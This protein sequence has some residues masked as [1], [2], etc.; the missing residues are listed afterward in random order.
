VVGALAVACLSLGVHPAQ[1]A[2]GEHHI[3]GSVFAAG[4]GGL[5]EVYVNLYRDDGSGNFV[6]YTPVDEDPD[7]H[8][9]QLVPDGRYKV[10]ISTADPES[11]QSEWYDD[12]RSKAAA[13]VVTLDGADVVLG[14]IL[15]EAVPTI[16]GKVVDLQGQPV[17]GVRVFPL[18]PPTYNSDW[19]AYTGPDGTFETQIYPGPWTLS[20]DDPQ[21]RFARE[22]RG[23][24][25]SPESST[26]FTVPRSG[27]LDVGTEVMSPG[28][29]IRGTVTGPDGLPLRSH[30]VTATA[31]SSEL[32]R[33]WT[34]RDGH[35]EL[36]LL[37]PGDYAVRFEDNA[38]NF[39]TEFY[40]DAGGQASALAVPVTEDDVTTAIDAQVTA[41]QHPVP[42]G[43][44]V[45]GVVTDAGGH[46]VPG[47]RV[48][49]YDGHIIDT[50]LNDPRDRAVT[51]AT[52]HYYLTDLDG[53]TA[54]T[55]KIYANSGAGHIENGDY[56]LAGQWYA[57]A[58]GATVIEDALPV[59]LVPGVPVSADIPLPESGLLHGR[60][61]TTGG[62]GHP[63]DPDGHV[64]ARDEH[65]HWVET[66]YIYSDVW[67]F[68]GGIA[69]GSY[70]LAPSG[71]G[72]PGGS[73]AIDVVVRSLED[74]DVPAAAFCRPRATVAPSVQGSPQ[75]SQI[76]T[77]D[78]GEW[79]ADS[80]VVGHEWLVD[81]TPAGTG[82]TYA[83]R[84][85]DAGHL[86]AVR[87]TR[88]TDFAC[89]SPV[90]GTATSASVQVPPPTVPTPTVPPP[91]PSQGPE[92][93]AS[94]VEVTAHV[95]RHA[96]RVTL[97]VTVT[98]EGAPVSGVVT[99]REGSRTLGTGTVQDGKLVLR[100]R[101]AKS[102]RHTYTIAYAGADGV[103]PSTATVRVRV[104]HNHA[105]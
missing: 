28:G 68:F 34:D 35:Y 103:L 76:V 102:G 90:T 78:P 86:L 19:A 16:T 6:F 9:S 5:P 43:V 67:Q 10:E 61:Y 30:R 1:A 7:P 77:F 56:L 4:G 49:A 101:G 73:S 50:F 64:V 89:C 24:A 93:R 8:F 46:P 69:P 97:K 36:P 88:M 80:V 23:D 45:S 74:T 26:V 70:R 22:Y 98:A 62:T 32:A 31:G 55:F 12:Q 65:G 100:L 38:D 83:V 104:R 92:P 40:D 54:P 20:F 59:G 47:A 84:E 57:G 39:I 91:P 87:V 79:S 58:S 25:N 52:G 33:D 82:P 99:L 96:P 42:P 3:S 2:A 15:I 27:A 72:C 29:S 18:R 48:F 41:I 11:F 51:D 63:G 21:F 94:S 66:A 60:T 53:Q 81:G 13:T 17:E 37:T 85:E 71:I 14:D 105:G 95:R 44:D 75:V